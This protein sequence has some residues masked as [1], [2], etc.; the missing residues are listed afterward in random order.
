M[1]LSKVRETQQKFTEQSEVQQARLRA[2]IYQ[3]AKDGSQVAAEAGAGTG[4]A[5][6][7]LPSITEA[8]PGFQGGYSKVAEESRLS[9]VGLQSARKP[10]SI[11]RR[12]G[13]GLGAGLGGDPERDRQGRGAANGAA[14]TNPLHTGDDWGPGVP[15][16]PPGGGGGGTQARPK[17]GY[18]VLTNER[19]TMDFI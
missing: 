13:A 10:G 9:R 12:A 14:E 1:R 11:L 19:G 5:D 16:F 18:R 4:F 8:G 15:R 3:R 7:P 6:A 2:Q 17:S